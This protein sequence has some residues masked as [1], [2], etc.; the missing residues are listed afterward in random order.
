MGFV[1][2][3]LRH[4][5]L[6]LNLSL[7]TTPTKPENQRFSDVFRGYRNRILALKVLMLLE[8]E[9]MVVGDFFICQPLR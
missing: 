1:L 7:H 4:K 2:K 3:I 8:T 6:A 9:I 5:I